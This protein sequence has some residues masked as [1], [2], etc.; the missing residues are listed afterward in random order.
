MRK[1]LASVLMT[2]SVLAVYILWSNPA[3]TNEGER[4]IRVA[5]PC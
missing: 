2:M 3:I 5:S 1:Y 4:V